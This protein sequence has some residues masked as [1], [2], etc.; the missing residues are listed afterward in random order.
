M[1]RDW[2]FRAATAADEPG[3]LALF[4]QTHGHAPTA[5][6]QAWRFETDPA[7]PRI[8]VIA[9]DDEQ[10]VGQ[11]ALWG[12]PLSIG[13][14]AVSGAQSL[15]TMT[16]PLYRGRGMFVTLAQACMELARERGVEVLY[17][18]PNDQSFPGF[19]RKLEWDHIG[20][21]PLWIRPL[22]PSR[23]RRMPRVLGPLADGI[24]GLLPKGRAGNHATAGAG[25]SDGELQTLLDSAAEPGDCRIDRQPPR[26]RWRFSPSAD[27]DYRWIGMRSADGALVSACVTGADIQGGNAL[28]S[29]LLGLTVASRVAALGAGIRQA[30]MA[31]KAFMLACTNDPEKIR[32]LRACGFFRY[33]KIPL[34]VRSLTSRPLAADIHRIENWRIFGADLDTF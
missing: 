13:G 14:Q 7:S 15:D 34:I 12:T 4:R 20:D 31:G 8:A 25:F 1:A 30:K 3:I 21:V 26:L 27:R 29:E 22:N 17:G 5:A 6:Y 24:A 9:E 32:T 28:V 33:R 19:V 16:H 18:F 10:I 2:T 23:H 11:Y